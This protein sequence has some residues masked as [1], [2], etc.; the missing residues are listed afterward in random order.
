LT[1]KEELEVTQEFMFSAAH[2]LPGYDGPCE[3]IHGHNYRLLVTVKGPLH[4]KSGM[5][6]DF[7]ALDEIV[8]DRIFPKLDHRMINDLLE[9]PTAENMIMWIWENLKDEL[10][11][12]C[13]LTLFEQPGSSVTYSG[14]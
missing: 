5:V 13:R 12:L 11:G 6:I 14:P 1:M 2:R 8:K 3:D 9:N 10:P 4:D 7:R